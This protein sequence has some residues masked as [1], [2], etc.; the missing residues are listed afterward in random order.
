MLKEYLSASRRE[1]LRREADANSDFLR[2]DAGCHYDRVITIDLGTL[3]PALNG[4]FSPGSRSQG[5]E[6]EKRKRKK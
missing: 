6:R 4:P 1:S 5:M 3:E 2:A